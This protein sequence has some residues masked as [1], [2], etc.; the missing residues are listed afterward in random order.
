M[1]AVGAFALPWVTLTYAGVEQEAVLAFAS[2]ASAALLSAGGWY[3]AREPRSRQPGQAPPLRREQTVVVGP[4][5]R[6]PNGFQERTELLEAVC[7]VMDRHRV[8][9][10]CALSGGRGVG[11]TQL[12]GAYARSR[13]A[14]GWRVVAWIVA[15]EPGQIVAGLDELAE[16]VGVKGGIQDAGLAATAARRWLEQLEEPALLV[17]DNVVDPD[18]VSRWLPRTGRTQTLLTSTV[19]SVDRLGATIAIE[20][21]SQREAV[22]F[23]R[24]MTGA[25]TDDDAVRDAEELA[26]ELGCLPL[27]L[28]Q[29]AGV[30]R[31][32]ALTFTEYR[33]RFRRHGVARVLRRRPG[34]PYPHGAAEA[35]L[36]AV[37]QVESGES[38]PIV[39][40]VVELL[41]LLSPSGVYRQDLKDALADRE[42]LE[43]DTVVGALSDASVVTLSLDGGIVLMHRLVQRIVRD[44]LLSDGRL[45]ERV[46][47]AAEAL[48]RLLG[49]AD[50]HSRRDAADRGLTDH[51]LALWTAAEPL[52]DEVRHA[53]MDLHRT[54]VHLLV[55]RA[56]IVRACTLGRDVLAEH[57]RLASPEDDRVLQAMA[58]LASAYMVAARFD[59]A[60]PLRR[61]YVAVHRQ[62]LGPEDPRTLNAV[63]SLGYV[64]EAA[65]RLDEA[66]ALHRRNLADS[67]RINGPDHQTTMYA[68]VNLASTLRSKG[69]SDLA[70]ELFRKNAADN[71]RAMGPDHP[72]TNNARGELARMCERVGRHAESLA[73]FDQVLA[74][75]TSG[76]DDVGL[77]WGRHRAHALISAGR[78]DEGMAELTRLL[79]RAEPELGRDHPETLCV[80]IFLARAHTAAGHHTTALALF[81]DCVEDRRHVLGPDHF[82]T[83]NAR[84]NLGLALLAAGKRSRAIACLKAVLDDYERVLGPHHPYTEGARA[85]RAGA[86]A[87]PRTWLPR[88]LTTPPRR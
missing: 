40:R 78:T 65:G 12:A 13:L 10:V 87:T 6:E 22:D 77:W 68:Q 21:F 39:G 46:P 57:E 32:Q 71:E 56:E 2:S 84:R 24:E 34:E 51:I 7:H 60:I 16:A 79:R 11:K 58:T 73:L 61:R 88:R 80:R 86:Q 37:G 52:G 18:E 55:E 30:I 15:E 50:D 53:L 72:S 26:E 54:A 83:L 1:S 17:L 8:A 70:L 41:S 36:E 5:P 35:L 82:A 74:H 23:L 42:P 76:G 20:V 4:L 47:E 28:A 27:A 33:Q 67:L 44:R 85:D 75:E 59:L 49:S 25:G 38:A 69:E 14:A 66:E 43:I 31:T 48:R 81:A 19:R 9:A 64:L 29:A 62:R 3:A 45:G 63:N